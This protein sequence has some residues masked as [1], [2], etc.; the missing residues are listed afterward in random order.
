MKKILYLI[1]I[2]LFFVACNNASN[3]PAETGNN[4]DQNK[5]EKS[6]PYLKVENT[7]GSSSGVV[8]AVSLVNYDFSPLGIQGGQSQTFILNK[9]MPGGY[10]NILI[11]VTFGSPGRIQSYFRTYKNFQDGTTTIVRIKT[12]NGSVVVE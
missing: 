3:T 5:N 11:S 9:G 10:D 8:M 6:C 1:V 7:L 4:N 2:C 12:S